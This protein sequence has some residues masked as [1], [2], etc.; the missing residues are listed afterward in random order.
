MSFKCDIMVEGILGAFLNSNLP[1]VGLYSSTS[2]DKPLASNGALIFWIASVIS[3][4]AIGFLE[5]ALRASEIGASSWARLSFML[6]GVPVN[7]CLPILYLL[8][9]PNILAYAL[10]A[11]SVLKR[12]R[13]T[14]PRFATA[15]QYLPI[16]EF[17]NVWMLENSCSPTA[18][19]NP[20]VSVS[21]LSVRTI[22]PSSSCIA[23]NA[24]PNGTLM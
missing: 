3:L 17:I 2:I 11:S 24:R 15:L 19:F 8:N 10:F 12:T 14:F 4:S 5:A 7:F 9:A 1:V 20:M 21:I 16:G 18:V 13:P 6:E 23:T 22:F